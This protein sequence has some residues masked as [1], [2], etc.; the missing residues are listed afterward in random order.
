VLLTE[1]E[2][3]VPPLLAARPYAAIHAL[4][5]ELLA[6]VKDNTEIE[7]HLKSY[8]VGQFKRV[9][10]HSRRAAFLTDIDRSGEINLAPECV[11]KIHGQMD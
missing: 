2:S 11:G 6:E 10:L 4:V 5:H 1:L 7:E 3:D 8:P 9:L